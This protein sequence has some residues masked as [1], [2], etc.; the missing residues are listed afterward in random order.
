VHHVIAYDNQGNGVNDAQGSF[1]GMYF[2][3]SVFNNALRAAAM[4]V[5]GI[6]SGLGF[7]SEGGTGRYPAVTVGASLKNT[8][9]F[10]NIIGGV[11]GDAAIS[12]YTK[13]ATNLFST[14]PGFLVATPGPGVV[15]ALTTNTALY[16][17][18]ARRTPN[19]NFGIVAGLN[20][21]A[22]STAIDRGTFVPGFHCDRAD[23]SSVPYPA[24]DPNCVHW[25]GAA[26]DIGAYEHGGG[27]VASPSP[28]PTGLQVK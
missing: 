24:D 11:A 21:S 9:S 13:L 6:W 28:A 22:G 26:P 15:S 4:S 8:I 3:L 2:H 19:A 14:D 23:D 1:N 20:L 17:D 18:A 5:P 7:E 16:T 27:Q 25:R 12:T 10:R